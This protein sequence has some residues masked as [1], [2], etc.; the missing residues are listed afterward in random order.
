MVGATLLLGS[1]EG[2]GAAEVGAGAAEVGAG[3]AEL[4]APGAGTS[5]GNP[6]AAQMPSRTV[7]TFSWSA[8]LG[9]AF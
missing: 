7:M 9:Q 1:S 8:V 2:L 3:A 5:M 4:D 6:A